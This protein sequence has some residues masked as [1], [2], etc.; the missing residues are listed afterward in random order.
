MAGEQGGFVTMPN[1][2]AVDSSPSHRWPK[3]S[4]SAAA[5]SRMGLNLLTS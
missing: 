3:G 2:V 5:S 4:S 1:T